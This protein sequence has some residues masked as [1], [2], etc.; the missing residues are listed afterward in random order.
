M[1]HLLLSGILLFASSAF[2]Y[3]D[4]TIRCKNQPGL[5]DNVYSIKTVNLGGG[6]QLPAVE[7]NRFS[8]GQ[9][10]QSIQETHIQGLATVARTNPE[11]ELL[12]IGA[13]RLEFNSKGELFGCKK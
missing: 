3:P 10:A 8:R 9:D 1:K 6:V 12:M 2:A 7:I 5:P 13:I 4:G 11:A